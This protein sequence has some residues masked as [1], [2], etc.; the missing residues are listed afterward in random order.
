MNNINGL[1]SVV[2]ERCFIFERL[3]PVKI[4][5]HKTSSVETSFFFTG[6][7]H[8][9]GYR[10]SISKPYNWL[11][12]ND[13]LTKV[14]NFGSGLTLLGLQ[15][16]PQTFVGIY[17]DNCPEWVITEHAA[18]SYSMVLV[19]LNDTLGPDACAFI[20]NQGNI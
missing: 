12:Y 18:Y 15:P 8:C 6:N 1:T 5:S 7:G 9:L 10:D 19:S 14:R 20:I 16:S 4:C 3:V 2:K 11:R 13:V 17:S